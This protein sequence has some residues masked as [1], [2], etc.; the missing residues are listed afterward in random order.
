MACLFPSC[1]YSYVTARSVNVANLRADI[2]K[3]HELH[4]FVVVV[5][6][7]GVLDPAHRVWKGCG[8]ACSSS[9]DVCDASPALI[10]LIGVFGHVGYRGG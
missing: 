6:G 4:K 1:R 10:R 5:C 8:S 7:L 2:R 3:T 9:S